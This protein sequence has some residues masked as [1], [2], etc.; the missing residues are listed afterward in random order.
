MK[1]MRI[2]FIVEAIPYEQGKGIEDGFELWS[3]VVIHGWI[4]TDNLIKM[5]KENGTIVCPYIDTSRGRS[6]IKE[7]D[8]IIIES[9]GNRHVCSGK[10]FPDRF[11][12]IK[13]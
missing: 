5:K 12:E 6:F 8:Y 11:E 9:D 3:D 1:Y 7:G 4:K 2:P 10:I 13:E